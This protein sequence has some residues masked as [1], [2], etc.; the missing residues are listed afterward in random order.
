MQAATLSAVAIGITYAAGVRDS[1]NANRGFRIRHEPGENVSY[2]ILLARV[3]NPQSSAMM[4]SSWR[5]RMTRKSLISNPVVRG[6]NPDPSACRVG[7]D[8]FLATSTGEF[9]PGIPIRHSTDLAHW[10]TIGYAVTRPEQYRRDGLP[11]QLKLYAPTLRHRKGRFYLACTNVAP[12]QGNFIVSAADPAGPWSDALWVDSDAF[13]PSL[14]FDGDTAYYTRRTVV[15]GKEGSGPVVQAEIDV[16]TG[17]LLTPTRAITPGE[18]GYR[19]NDIEGPHLYRVGDWWYLFSAEGGTWKGHMQTVARSRSP[20]GP[21]DGFEGNPVLTH[22]HRVG[23]PIQSTGHAELIDDARGNWWAL[24]LGTRHNGPTSWHHLGRETFLAPVVWNDGWPVLGNDGT[25]ELEHET[26]QQLPAPGPE[27]PCERTPWTEGWSTREP[28]L[29]GL[30]MTVDLSEDAT[31]ELPESSGSIQQGGALAAVFLRQ[32][33]FSG[34]FRASIEVVPT[35]PASAGVSVYA[36]PLH[37]YDLLASAIGEGVAVTLH[38]RVGDMIV[39]HVETFE[40]A[41]GVHLRVWCTP[42]GYSFA[43][44]KAGAT[45]SQDEEWVNVGAGEARL[46]SA[47]TS[48]TYSGI[49]FGVLATRARTR[50]TMVRWVPSTIGD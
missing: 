49:R 19:S 12:G 46:V 3:T 44:R 17:V 35:H 23:H 14:A 45:G 16:A 33:E 1:S 4:A 5:F 15:P 37:H 11:G 7:E 27:W 18:A 41:V 38:K 21:F 6:L 28:P 9:W 25:V 34:E 47:E 13:D 10:R 26:T 30:R 40:T 48:Q 39:E 24:F 42:Q 29:E 8:F 36:S 43:A 50:F 32:T 2:K 22:R 20:F 31:V